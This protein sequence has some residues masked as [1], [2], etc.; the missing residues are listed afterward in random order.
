M[1]IVGGL[2]ERIN[3]YHKTEE[4]PAQT[5]HAV[6]SDTALPSEVVE[7]L[8]IQP[9]EWMDALRQATLRADVYRILDL[10]GQIRERNPDLAGVLADLTERYEYQ[11]ILS[12]IKEAGGER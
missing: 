2:N 1:K 9:P 7:T 4:G 6:E 8:A 5:T 11:Q 12:L 10:I 3:R